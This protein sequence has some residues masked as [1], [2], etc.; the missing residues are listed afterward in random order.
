MQVDTL[1]SPT[2]EIVSELT[3]LFSLEKE[4]EELVSRSSGT[5]FQTFDWQRLWWKHFASKSHHLFV[6][7]VRENGRLIGIAPFFLQTFEMMGFRTFRQL[8]LIGSGLRSERSPVLSVEREGPGDYL[9][10]IAERGQEEK[11]AQSVRG[12]VRDNQYLW[13]EIELQNLP[14]DGILLNQVLPGMQG[15][16]FEVAKEPTDVC[17]KVLLPNSLDEYLASLRIK[18]RRNLRHSYR[19]YFEDPEFTVEDFGSGQNMEGALQALSLLHQKRW[20]MVGYPGLFSDNRFESMQRELVKTLNKSDRIWIKILRHKGK[21]VAGR[22]G[23]KF[24][25]QVCD[26]LSGFELGQQS[27]SGSYSGTGMALIVSVI[28]QSIDSH[29]RVFD[30]ARGDEAYKFDLT[31]TI[32]RNYRVKVLSKTLRR[33]RIHAAY[34]ISSAEYSLFSRIACESD[35]FKLRAKEKGILL[36][37]PSYTRH[38]IERLSG[39]PLKAPAFFRGK[40]ITAFLNGKHG[41]NRE[42]G[43][44]GETS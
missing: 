28:K 19:A 13:D 14:E 22:L 8:K 31:S 7:L 32:Y 9:D 27:G 42:K 34:K 16:D 25:G 4:W 20:N 2:V 15:P 38:V 33:R 40:G 30:L 29:M 21:P 36:A 44:I 6:V 39:H 41:S 26:Y 24:N 23:F 1:S 43:K 3:S 18:V 10:V 37:V 5:I 12:F 11:V 35:I 17:P